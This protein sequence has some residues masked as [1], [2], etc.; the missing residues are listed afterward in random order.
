MSY[1]IFKRKA[2]KPNPDWPEGFEPHGSAYKTN[3]KIVETEVE[4]KMIC[5]SHNVKRPTTGAKRYRFYFFEYT[6]IGG[7]Q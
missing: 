4:A 6:K 7:D 1:Q 3:I 5:E 2:Y